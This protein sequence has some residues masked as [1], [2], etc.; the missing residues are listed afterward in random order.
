[1]KSRSKAGPP[2]ARRAP[3]WD[4]VVRLLHWALAL[5]VLFALV[6]DDGDWWHREHLIRSGRDLLARAAALAASL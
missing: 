1:M 5:L 6:R 4:A 3:V 2:A